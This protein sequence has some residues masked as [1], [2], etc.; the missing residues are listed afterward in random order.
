MDRCLVP[1]LGM[2]SFCLRSIPRKGIVAILKRY[3]KERQKCP[4][5]N[6]LVSIEAVLMLASACILL[7]L[8]GLSMLRH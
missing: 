2:R 3:E 4:D 1:G 5:D 8:V 6:W 7:A